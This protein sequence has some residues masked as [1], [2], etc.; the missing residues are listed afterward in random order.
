MSLCVCTRESLPPSSSLEREAKP[1]A[2]KPRFGVS[3][4]DP[5]PLV[6]TCPKPMPN[7]LVLLL[8]Q[9]PRLSLRNYAPRLHAQSCD[10]KTAGARRSFQRR[11]R[12]K[13]EFKT[14]TFRRWLIDTYSLH[15][16]KAGSGILDVA[17]GKGE[18]AF[19]FV[20]LNDCP[21]TVVDPRPLVLARYI[22]RME[23]GIYWR[24]EIMNRYNTARPHES[25]IPQ[26]LRVMFEIPRWEVPGGEN[27]LGGAMPLCMRS[28]DAWDKAKELA[29]VR[30]MPLHSARFP[31]LQLACIMLA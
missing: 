25:V 6:K 9:F 1:Q 5:S 16:L 8:A 15:A 30:Y 29:M 20:N 22:K 4:P 3:S 31:H 7:N 26:H 14:G 24:N 12:L 10:D 2:K 27:Y 23:M 18:L 11:N 19:E 21:C 28:H 13:N 17:G